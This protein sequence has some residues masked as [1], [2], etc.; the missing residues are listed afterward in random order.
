M[1]KNEGTPAYRPLPRQV[2]AGL[3]FK[4]LPAA[5]QTILRKISSRA[6]QLLKSPRGKLIL[7]SF[8]C[9]Y[10]GCG[11][12][13][14]RRVFRGGRS[15]YLDALNF[16]ETGRAATLSCTATA[17]VVL[18]LPDVWP[19]SLVCSDALSSPCP[20]FLDAGT[21]VEIQL[22]PPSPTL[23]SSRHRYSRLCG[24]G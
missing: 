7:F 19:S 1:T 12:E 22:R 18:F 5:T 20:R 24:Q 15:Y 8:A 11:E 13:E 21:W 17:R 10:V 4:S 16:N 23:E 6:A 14:G 3:E 2:Q 9:K